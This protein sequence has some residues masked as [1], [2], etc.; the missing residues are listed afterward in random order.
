MLRRISANAFCTSAA[1][2]EQLIA[3]LARRHPAG[4]FSPVNATA[5]ALSKPAAASRAVGASSMIDAELTGPE[6]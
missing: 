2:A 3:E 1:A 5:A 4:V 6:T